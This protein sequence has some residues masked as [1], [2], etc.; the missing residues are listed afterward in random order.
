MVLYFSATGNTE[1]VARELARQ[2]NDECVDLLPR[3]KTGDHTPLH[4]NRPF[5]VC[6][7]IYVC[8]MPRFLSKY[9]K[10]Q[11]FTGSSD[12]YCAFTSGGYCGIAGPL[13]KS[14]FRKKGMTYRGHAEITMPRNYVANDTYPM[15]PPKQVEERICKAK[16]QIDHAVSCIR[17]GEDLCARHVFLFESLITLP[18]N[19]VWCKYKLTA[20]D[21][22]TTDKCVGCGKCAKLCPLNNITIKDGRPV[23]GD[24]CTHCMACIANCPTECIEYGT[25]SQ[26]KERY[27]F[28]KY[29]HVVNDPAYIEE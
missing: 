8:E 14:L 16:A 29:R 20:K 26:G 27:T 22:Y 2:L 6:A 19:P 25:L 9:L 4:S 1:Y 23:W 13:A 7:P 24:T 18:F 21:F 15:L 12:I 3:I 17:A 28:K 5:I 11:T 10:Q